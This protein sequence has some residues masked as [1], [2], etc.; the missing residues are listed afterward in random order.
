MPGSLRSDEWEMGTSSVRVELTSWLG[1]YF[2]AERGGRAVVE[3]EVADAATV[4][5][6]LEDLSSHNREFRDVLF[7]PG[8]GRMG[9]YM[10]VVLNGRLL[11]LAGGL[12]TELKPGDTVLLMAA[13]AGG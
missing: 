8:T 13:L 12:E 6:L 4:K 7:D 5:D 2:G 9:R 11:E 10:T 3:R 1:R